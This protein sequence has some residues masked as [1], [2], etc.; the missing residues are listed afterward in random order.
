M[1]GVLTFVTQAELVEPRHVTDHAGA[2]VV[3]VV[4]H[5]RGAGS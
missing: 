3:A 5:P 4:P 1:L 2:K